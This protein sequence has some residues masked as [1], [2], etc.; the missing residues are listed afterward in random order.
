MFQSPIPVI[1][2]YH[3]QLQIPP[4]RTAVPNRQPTLLHL[5]PLLILAITPRYLALFVICKGVAGAN[6]RESEASQSPDTP[7][8]QDRNPHDSQQASPEADSTESSPGHRHPPG[9]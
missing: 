6:P 1:A 9:E 8:A 5:A 3:L 4:A 7:T 2:E